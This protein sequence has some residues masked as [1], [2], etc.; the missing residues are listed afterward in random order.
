MSTVQTTRR[1]LRRTLPYQVAAVFSVAV[2]IT[3]AAAAAIAG[4]PASAT[5][6]GGPALSAVQVSAF[7]YFPGQY[8]NEA[9]AVEPETPTFYALN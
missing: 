1:K 3:F 9:T 7:E 6:A 8:E 4:Y 2:A 5:E